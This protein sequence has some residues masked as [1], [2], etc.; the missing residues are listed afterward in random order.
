[1]GN[2]HRHY[3]S[4]L[5]GEMVLVESKAFEG[6][7]I[8]VE[9][10]IDAF[11]GKM[12]KEKFND[13]ILNEYSMLRWIQCQFI[14]ISDETECVTIDKFREYLPEHCA[15][16]LEAEYEHLFIGG[17]AKARACAMFTHGKYS[18][19]KFNREIFG[20]YKEN[21]TCEEYSQ[22]LECEIKKVLREIFNKIDANHSGK[23]TIKEL[24]NHVKKSEIND[25]H[26]PI[27]GK[28]K[29]RDCVKGKFDQNGDN[30]IDF[31]E[32]EDFFMKEWCFLSAMQCFDL[33]L[34]KKINWSKF[35]GV[36]VLHPREN[37]DSTLSTDVLESEK[38]VL[39]EA[40]KLPHCNG[41]FFV[42]KDY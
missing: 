28:Y 36:K 24:I 21:M 11:K 2:I 13:C 42:A 8:L 15:S 33:S 22:M 25:W 4:H 14:D 18:L 20:E 35:E 9:M 10:S 17:R 23:I 31:E 39:K 40:K 3:K 12:D 27:D 26:M 29:I 41:N 38:F 5:F 16:Q 19:H 6:K 7:E 32:F 37:L 34:V 1:M 30:R